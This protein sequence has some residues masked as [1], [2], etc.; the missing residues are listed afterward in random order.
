MNKMIYLTVKQ[1]EKI[2]KISERRIRAKIQQGHFPNA[3]M[4]SCGVSWII[5][6][7]DLDKSKRNG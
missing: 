6:V 2:L 3:M 4:C 5:P 1:A 7:S